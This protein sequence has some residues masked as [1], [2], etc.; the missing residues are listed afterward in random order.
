MSGPLHIRQRTVKADGSHPLPPVV[1]SSPFAMG[2]HYAGHQEDTTAPAPPTQ[3]KKPATSPFAM[4]RQYAGDRIDLEQEETPAEPANQEKPSMSTATEGTRR[5]PRGPQLVTRAKETLKACGPLSI[6]QFAEGLGIDFP[7]A[8][9]LA[10]N[11]TARGL[12]KSVRQDDGQMKLVLATSAADAP[13]KK[14]GK[15]GLKRHLAKRARI[16]AA[17][18]KKT[19]ARKASAPRERLPA[20][21]VVEVSEGDQARFG[22]FNTGEFRI[23]YGGQEMKLPRKVTREMV[24]YLDK[25]AAALR[26]D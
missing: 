13:K 21:A 18:P 25:I 2:D 14:G 5:G 6:E 22:L 4:A 3:E 9:T 15:S 8:K 12:W 17:A 23:E 24:A 7:K 10:K 20:T 11:G 1:M 19:R 16:G 26:E